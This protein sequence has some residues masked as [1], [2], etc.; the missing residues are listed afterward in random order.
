MRRGMTARGLVT[1]A[2]GVVV[3]IDQAS[4][5][6]HL[7]PPLWRSLLLALT[8][9]LAPLLAPRSPITS[10]VLT[11]GLLGADALLGPQG[12]FFIPFVVSTVAVFAISAPWVVAATS[13]VYAGFA[14]R[15]LLEGQSVGA[16]QLIALACC[17]L[18]GGLVRMGRLKSRQ[19]DS[20][21]LSLTRSVAEIRHDTRRELGDEL[22]SLL[23]ADLT[24]NQRLLAEAAGLEPGQLRLLL[25][26]IAGRSRMSL[27]RLRDLV[28][29]LRGT[30]G[31]ATD[32]TLGESVE[33]LEDELVNLG[34]P[35]R[36]SIPAEVATAPL[37]FHRAL[38]EVADH[39]RTA[40]V[41][42]AEIVVV[43]TRDDDAL[44][45]HVGY[46]TTHAPRDLPGTLRALEAAIEEAGGTLSCA[47]TPGSES[48]DLTLPVAPAVPRRMAREVGT[49]AWGRIA[50]RAIAVGG[51]MWA[52]LALLHESATS[53]EPTA[54]ALLW[55]AT[56]GAALLGTWRI[57]A[58]IAA[59]GVVLLTGLWVPF[60][61]ALI[62]PLHASLT[63]LGGLATVRRTRWTI[64]ALAG[65]LG[66]L[67]LW[68]LGQGLAPIVSLLVY[69]FFGLAIGT[70]L[71]EFDADR[72]RQQDHLALLAATAA[73]AR[74]HEQ[75]RLAGDLH[76][77]IAHQLSQ[78]SMLV[79]THADSTD[80]VLLRGTLVKVSDLNQRAR[81]DLVSLTQ[82]MRSEPVGEAPFRRPPTAVIA[83]SIAMLR[84]TGR[85][86]DASID[87]AVD[88]VEGTT[89]HTIARIASEAA[90]N[91]VRYAPPDGTVRV[92]VVCLVDG[93]SL[94]VS[95][96]LDG[97]VRTSPDST[98]NGLL[99]LRERVAM[100]GGNFRAGPIGGQWV[101]QALLPRTGLGLV[102]AD[103]GHGTRIDDPQL[104]A[105]NDNLG[106][107]GDSELL[108][109]SS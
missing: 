93:V 34:H 29:T 46:P 81:E 14:C 26:D 79:T 40:A 101:V 38:R 43:V 28:R 94:A 10:V 21:I 12:F 36:L 25:L 59:L 7:P 32:Q 48:L 69:P 37:L 3:A 95:S 1:L 30:A 56:W 45:L 2:I 107:R 49:L 50:A 6:G 109:K 22:A 66:F 61:T 67:V 20:T 99:G 35:V 9:A 108:G 87:P 33:A 27:A 54:T 105:P 72:A 73:E 58:G 97:V 51:A 102:A 98:G 106:P 65:A 53:P 78:I 60:S 16:Y 57:R 31:A 44:R 71:A 5:L 82:L 8:A 39:T 70:T 47:A 64:P 103:Q 85:R 15:S 88:H 91:I 96:P 84:D 86:V 104:N 68:G 55:V 62:H 13:I 100:T 63:L 41:P 92:T 4:G 90:T 11:S 17:A 74:A 83:E 19:T 77:I 18:A 42:G 76:D 23:T 89:R 75:R 24:E 52:M 80:P